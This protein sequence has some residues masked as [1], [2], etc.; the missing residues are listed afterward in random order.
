MAEIRLITY[1]SLELGQPRRLSRHAIPETTYRKQIDLIRNRHRLVDAKELAG[2]QTADD[3]RHLASTSSRDVYLLTFDDG[4]IEH[5][6]AAEILAEAGGA[7]IFFVTS[8]TPRGRLLLANK[9]HLLDLHAGG[10]DSAVKAIERAAGE[11]WR[12]HLIEA[13]RKLL[14]RVRKA[15]FDTPDDQALKVAIQELGVE[16]PL[17]SA[18]DLAIAAVVPDSAAVGLYADDAGLQQIIACGSLIGGHGR[19]HRRLPLLDDAVQLEEIAASMAF[20][21]RFHPSGP[22]HFAHPYGTYNAAS[23]AALT[24]AGFEFLHTIESGSVGPAGANPHR[25]PRIDVNSL[26]ALL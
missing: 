23:V 10:L 15:S 12:E 25:L 21:R 2:L 24:A 13:G 4:Y 17:A 22:K 19:T 6:R 1:H 11:P 18:I 16:D 8:E 3:L 9:L 26:D 5:A 20:L 7:G 14:A